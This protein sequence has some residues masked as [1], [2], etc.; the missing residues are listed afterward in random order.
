MGAG[1]IRALREQVPEA[2]FFGIGG[3]KMAAA[4]CRL[5]ANPTHHAT[6]LFGSLGQIGYWMKLLRAV[7]GELAAIRPA[8]VIPIDSPAL[9]VRIARIARSLRLPVCYYV[10]PQHWAW[11]PWRTRE[12]ARVV[13]TLCCILPFEPDYFSHQGLHAVFV[14]HPIF[15]TAVDA[16]A[17]DPARL[18]PPLPTG[19]MRVALL[20]GSRR[21]E[22][23]M[24]MPVLLEV[25]ATLKGRLNT[26]VF[27]A[28]AADDNRAL[29]MQRYLQRTHLRVDV[30]THRADE[31]LRWADMVLAVS[32]TVS[33][34]VAKYHK[35]M[36]IVYALAR[37]KWHLAGRFLINTKYMCLV[38]ILADRALVPEFMPFYG[39]PEKIARQ[40][41]DLAENSDRRTQM[42]ADLARLVDPLAVYSQAKPA[43]ERVA[44]EVMKL[45]GKQIG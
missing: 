11:A 10:A 30:R 5:L 20:P 39:S 8:V 31:V 40:A 15:D 35:P 2:R 22:V 25:A 23:Q 16:P 19:A 41:L 37:W 6:M 24:N 28:A 1:L 14:G 36:I 4:G 38:N 29:Q 33:L 42:A 32:G 34:Q 17:T 7:K 3:D 44:L 43:S 27:A 21:G 9:N 45:M 13:D 18:V 12:L 26:C